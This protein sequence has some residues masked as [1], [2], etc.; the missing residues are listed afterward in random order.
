MKIVRTALCALV[1]L[2]ST[3]YASDLCIRLRNLN[4]G[5]NTLRINGCLKSDVDTAPSKSEKCE[6][7]INLGLGEESLRLEGCF[8]RHRSRAQD[9]CDIRKSHYGPTKTEIYNVETG[10]NTK[11]LTE[12]ERPLFVG[13]TLPS[14]TIENIKQAEGILGCK[15]KPKSCHIREARF[16]YRGRSRLYGQEIY[17]SDGTLVSFVK[18]KRGFKMG[19][20][21]L[22]TLKQSAICD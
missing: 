6:I 12:S 5:Q 4:V 8:G 10:E 22:N 17:N 1:L 2:S 3:S 11:D 14:K 21:A 19:Q 9:E 15:F 16:T 18:L 7:L 20:Q 13:G